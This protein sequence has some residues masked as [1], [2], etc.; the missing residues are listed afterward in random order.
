MI[1]IETTDAQL[2]A[3]VEKALYGRTSLQIGSQRMAIDKATRRFPQGAVVTGQVCVDIATPWN[4]EGLPPVGTRCE[5]LWSSLTGEYVL[6]L[7]VGHD[8]DYAVVRTLTG[9]RKGEY[10]AQ[11]ARLICGHPNLRPFRSAE[12]LAAEQAL[13]E[14]EALY[15]EGGPAAVYDAGYRKQPE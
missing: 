13:S 6:A 14:I 12:Q 1:K 4:G 9:E 11:A 2:A 15:A 7:V 8:E 3:D 10:S 5:V